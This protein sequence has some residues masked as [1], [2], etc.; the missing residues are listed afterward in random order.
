MAHSFPKTER[1]TSKKEISELFTKGSFFVVYPLK[2]LC[3]HEDLF[4]ASLPKVLTTVPKRSFKKATDRN[5]IKRRIREAYRK[6][7]HTLIAAS[8]RETPSIKNLGFIYIAKEL[9][10]FHEIESAM[11][12]ALSKLVNGS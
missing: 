9:S 3:I 1:L 11:I 12:K 10:S 7:K 8:H 2:V 4:Q 6:Q 5:F